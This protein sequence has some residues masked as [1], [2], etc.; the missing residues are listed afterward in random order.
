MTAT[1]CTREAS[2]VAATGAEYTISTFIG[3]PEEIGSRSAT[4]AGM[5]RCG[6]QSD[7]FEVDGVVGQGVTM[8]QEQVRT[9]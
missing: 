1:G 6:V 9:E 8:R 3:V 7:E 4:D 5:T 2:E